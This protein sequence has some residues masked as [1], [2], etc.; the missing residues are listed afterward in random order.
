MLQLKTRTEIS[1]QAG[2]RVGILSAIIKVWIL[3][4]YIEFTCKDPHLYN[5]EL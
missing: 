4:D 1:A 5:T 3:N 2:I